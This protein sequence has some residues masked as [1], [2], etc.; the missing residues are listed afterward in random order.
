MMHIVQTV[1]PNIDINK[2]LNCIRNHWITRTRKEKKMEMIAS[3]TKDEIDFSKV[4]FI[5]SLTKGQQK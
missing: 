4:L 1:D 2:K 5:R 3:H